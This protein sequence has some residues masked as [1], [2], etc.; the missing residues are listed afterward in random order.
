VSKIMGGKNSGR[1]KTH[2]SYVHILFPVERK[3]GFML[4]I[5][6]ITVL[7]FYVNLRE[8]KRK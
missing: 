8:R 4:N 2:D 5:I 3:Q 7:L 1:E 6:T